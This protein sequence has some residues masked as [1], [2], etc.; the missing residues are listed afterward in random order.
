MPILA[1]VKT[2]A[3]LLARLTEKDFAA[4]FFGTTS[5]NFFHDRPM[6]LRHA[7]AIFLQVGRAVLAKDVCE[8]NFLLD[9][10]I[11]PP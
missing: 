4:K 10:L 2:V 8:F 3:I 5:D 7:L 6:A 1:G 11:N 9:T